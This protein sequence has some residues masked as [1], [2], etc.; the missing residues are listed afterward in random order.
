[1]SATVLVTGPS[2]KVGRRLIPLLARKGLTVRAASRSPVGARAGIEPVRFDWTDPSTFEAAR[3]GVEAIYL[4]PGPVPQPEHADYMRLLL[5]GAARAGVK[6]VVLLSVFGLDQAP[7]DDPLRRIE[8]AVE[9]SGVPYT[10]L[11]PGAFMQ[12]FSEG[13]RW[14][15]PFAEVIRER[16]EIVN[17]GGAGVVSYVSSEDI[18]AVAAVALT[19]NGHEGKGY[20][21]LGPEPLTLMQVAEHISWAAGRPIRYVEI[22]HAPMRD[23]LLAMGTPP[24]IAEH[25]SRLYSFA[26]TS[27]VFGVLNDDILN[28]TG[29]PPQSFGEFAVGAAAAWRR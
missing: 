19:E 6:R 15:E 8:L 2:G 20:A 25:N 1:M 13:L 16:D 29:Q 17:P 27:G 3:K 28:V 26:F 9:S 22:D 14:N 11:R 10:L 7:P 24:E 23:K 4:V 18:A 5:D 12:N 21:L